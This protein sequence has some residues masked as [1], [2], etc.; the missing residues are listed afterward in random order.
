MRNSTHLFLNISDGAA[1]EVQEPI[2]QFDVEKHLAQYDKEEFMQLVYSVLR[3]MEAV[4][5]AGQLDNM[6][7]HAQE[8]Q[9]TQ[10]G[11]TD[12]AAAEVEASQG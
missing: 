6:V 5:A 11:E 9:Q 10:A 1:E 7:L 3:D 4:H 12:K 2:V 8:L